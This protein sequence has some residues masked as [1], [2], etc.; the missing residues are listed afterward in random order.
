MPGSEP[1]QSRHDILSAINLAARRRSIRTGGQAMIPTKTVLLA[2]AALLAL[3]VFDA[4]KSASTAGD[5][6][7]NHAYCQWYKQKAM[8]TGDEYW[9]ARWRRCLRGYDWD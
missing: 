7:G 5:F 2:A 9:W 3:T 6:G 8:N 4:G 1:V